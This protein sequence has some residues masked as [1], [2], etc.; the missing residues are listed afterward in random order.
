MIRFE[1]LLP[2]FH[3]DGRPVDPGDF[4]AADDELQQCFKATST[5]TVIV[6]GRWV[7][8]SLTYSDQLIRVRVDV[9]D[10]PENWE[11]IRQVKESFKA[12]FAQIDIWIT[13]HHI[14][15]V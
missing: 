14:E 7:Y 13:A 3:N 1:I 8:Q 4:V 5:E 9:D 6:H 10:T 11:M 15:V 12:R 2:L